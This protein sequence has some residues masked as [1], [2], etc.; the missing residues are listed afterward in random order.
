MSN[1]H[2][3]AASLDG[4]LYVLTEKGGKLV[5]QL[6]LGKAIS[7]SPAASNGWLVVGNREGVLYGLSSRGA[8]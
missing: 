4:K 1:G 7:A 8:P 3:Y 2:V 5:Q 6:P